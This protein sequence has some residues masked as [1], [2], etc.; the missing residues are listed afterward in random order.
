MASLIFMFVLVCIVNSSYG[1]PI[2]R[3]PLF[4]SVDFL[5]QEER[6]RLGDILLP[7]QTEVLLEFVWERTGRCS[8]L[9]H[10]NTGDSRLDD[11][12]AVCDVSFNSIALCG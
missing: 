9:S 2:T 3:N 7:E 6:D 11:T 10:D 1:D 4:E 12:P 8:R 5:Q